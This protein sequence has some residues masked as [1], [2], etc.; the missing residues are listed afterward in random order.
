MDK[1]KECGREFKTERSLH[2][3]LK[4]HKITVGQYYQQYYPRYDL[5]SGKLI[6]FKNKKLYL[7]KDFNSLSNFRRWVET[8]DLQVVKNYC[9]HLIAKRK[10][11]KGMS[12][13]MSQIELRS[14]KMPSVR[15]YNKLFGDYYELCSSLG[16]KNKFENFDTVDHLK[17]SALDDYTIYIDSR[18]QKPL[19]FKER[20]TVVRGLKF[21]DYA[22]ENEKVE[23]K[24][25]IERKSLADLVG[26]LS[27]HNFDR[28]R[29]E[30]ERAKENDSHLVILIENSLKHATSFDFLRRARSKERIFK[31]TKITP[32]FLLRQI[33][34]LIQEY[35]FIQF[36]FVNGRKEASRVVQKIFEH[37]DIYKKVDLQYAY[38][39]DKL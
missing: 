25:R 11:E 18:E 33:R 3:H 14:L 23:C 24:C 2:A 1:C 32:Q 12:Y 31:D 38:D 30:I 5:Y 4:A 20:P 21:G 9:S 35:P 28:F 6:T 19:I 16:L 26:T 22:F 27:P 17:N 39:I 34:R 13:S 7:K 15:I 8:E 37:G 29:K 10:K 36:L